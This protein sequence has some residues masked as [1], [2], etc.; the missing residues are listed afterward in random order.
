MNFIKILAFV[1][2]FSALGANAA[3]LS[4]GQT[5]TVDGATASRQYYFV[6][7]P[8]AASN[9]EVSVA[10]GTGDVDL[11]TRFN[12]V[13][14]TTTYDCRPFQ[15]D[16]NE[17]CSVLK[18]A[19]GRH[20]IMLRAY[21]A[22][23]GALLSVS[24]N[25]SGS[26]TP[27]PKPTSIPTPLPTTPPATDGSSIDIVTYNIE[28]LGRPSTAGY[29]GTREQQIRAAANDIIDGGGDIYALQEIGGSAV[30][31]ELLAVLNSIDT[32][33]LWAGAVSQPSASQS[34]AYVYKGSIIAASFQTILTDTSSRAFAG[35]YPYLM[36]ASI[37]VDGHSKLLN[38][39]NLHLKCCT[40]ESNAERRADAMAILLDE[41]AANYRTANMIVLGDLN[42]AS[43]GGAN[44]EIADWGMYLDRDGDALA[45]YS[46]AAGSVTDEPYVPSN[47]DSDIDHI[48]ISDEL[49]AA[50][51]AISASLRNQYLNTSV[52]DH[53]PVKTSLDISLF[54]NA[55][56]APSPNPNP[57]SSPTAMPSPS[58][59]PGPQP[60]SNPDALSVT[61][62]LAQ[63][64]GSALT[65][66]GVI[67]EAFNDIYALRMRDKNTA[68]TI[69]VKLESAQRDKWSPKLRP[70]LIGKS[71]EVVGKRDSYSNLPSI[72]SVSSIVVLD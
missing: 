10:G 40:G 56:P 55:H 28:W 15:A 64:K 18:P 57:S 22:F 1:S 7:L 58:A 32:Q 27:T 4:N 13:P 9:L 16:N 46:H 42:V 14:N 69:I 63:P 39:I 5:L 8:E 25:R 12:A 44:G 65:A 11:Y 50:W 20:H 67:V 68:D 31:N 61:E 17:R 59:T 45:D 70:E 19:A 52:S 38:L 2:V 71:I 72:E 62:A 60:S 35:R 37:T 43:H 21:K 51:H 36:T 47:P 66:V 48:L 49:N 54:A 30:L 26:A 6:E 53:S 24:F 34:L 33:S 41:L 23:D 29:N 3:E